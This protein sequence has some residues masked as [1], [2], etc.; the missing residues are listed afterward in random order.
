VSVAVK[1]LSGVHGARKRTAALYAL[2]P[3]SP[4][5]GVRLFPGC[6]GPSG[7]EIVDPGASYEA[8]FREKAL[9]EGPK[10]IRRRKTHGNLPFAGRSR[11]VDWI[12]DREVAKKPAITMLLLGPAGLVRML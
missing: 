10:R 11:H 1:R 3:G 9:F 4:A 8:V 12:E 5:Y 7:E 2:Q 6:Q